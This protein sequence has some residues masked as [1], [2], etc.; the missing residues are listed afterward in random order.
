M[1]I[2]TFAICYSSIFPD[3]SKQAKDN[4]N[5]LTLVCNLKIYRNKFDIAHFVEQCYDFIYVLTR[6]MFSPNKKNWR[7]RQTW[8]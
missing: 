4:K 2:V 8:Y 6:E 7:T 1:V 3:K 5:Q